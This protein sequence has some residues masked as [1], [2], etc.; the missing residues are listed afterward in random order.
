[1]SLRLFGELWEK[2]IDKRIFEFALEGD[3][4]YKY[5]MKNGGIYSFKNAKFNPKPKQEV[6]CALQLFLYKE[7]IRWIFIRQY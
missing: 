2:K 7:V 3:V 6:T 1:M 4:L 5:L